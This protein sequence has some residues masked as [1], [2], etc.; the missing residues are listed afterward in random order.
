MN[1]FYTDV[2]KRG[3]QRKKSFLF[4]ALSPRTKELGKPKTYI[5]LRFSKS[6][7]NMP[8]D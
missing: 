6:H 2:F 4:H 5:F 8:K 1:I 3:K 7:Y